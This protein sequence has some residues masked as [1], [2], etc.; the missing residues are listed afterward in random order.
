[1]WDLSPRASRIRA[2]TAAVRPSVGITVFAPV[3]LASWAGGGAC[4]G[5][6]RRSASRVLVRLHERVPGLSVQRH[7][8]LHR[9]ELLHACPGREKLDRRESERERG[10]RARISKVAVARAGEE[11]VLLVVDAHDVE[12]STRTG[13]H[14][15]A[16]PP[17][18]GPPVSEIGS[19]LDVTE[20][21]SRFADILGRPAHSSPYGA[22]KRAISASRSALIWA[23]SSSLN[24][25]S[26]RRSAKSW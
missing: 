2:E 10:V 25:M 15:L 12:Q 16:G 1:M 17:T 23:T 22:P 26:P 3:S 21:G 4:D 18:V 6:L 8:H 7:D 19:V 14:V 9:H 13:M 5:A 11:Y 20:G 24:G